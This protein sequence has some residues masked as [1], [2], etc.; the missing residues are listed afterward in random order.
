M[1]FGP[2]VA[3]IERSLRAFGLKY[4]LIGFHEVGLGFK[5]VCPYSSSIE[6]KDN[7][8]TKVH[9]LAS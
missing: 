4:L 6:S 7:L 1:N 5:E 3:F 8:V 2:E 9:L